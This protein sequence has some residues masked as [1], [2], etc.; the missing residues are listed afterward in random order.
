MS[1]FSAVH[2]HPLHVP[3][4]RHFHAIDVVWA[5]FHAA[6]RP[7]RIDYPEPLNF[8]LE[9]AAMAREMRRL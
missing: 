3:H 7:D 5:I 8:L 6:S 1:T 9:D 4:L 2:A